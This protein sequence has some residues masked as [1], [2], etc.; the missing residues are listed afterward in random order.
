MDSDKSVW[1]LWGRQ[2]RPGSLALSVVT[3]ALGV[4][5]LLGATR[6]AGLGETLAACIALLTVAALWV[7]WWAQGLRAMLVGLMGAVWTWSVVA[8]VAFEQGASVMTVIIS[9]CWALL[10]ALLFLRDRRERQ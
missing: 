7:G 5:G 9:A 1:L 6:L 4:A 3:G 2:V 10:A 8:Y